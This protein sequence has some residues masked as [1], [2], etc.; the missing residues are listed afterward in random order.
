M[1]FLL[2]G[3][4]A[5]GFTIGLKPVGFRREKNLRG[6]ALARAQPK[7]VT[8]RIDQIGAV[9][10]VEVEISDAVVDQ[11]EHLFGGDRGRDQLAG[12]RISSR[13]SKRAASQSGTEAPVRAAK[14]LVCLKFCTGGCRARPGCRC[15][16][17]HALEIAEIHAVFEK[18]LGDCARRAGI[19]FGLEHVDVGGDAG[20]VGVLFS[21]YAETDTSISAMRLIPAT[22]SAALR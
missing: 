13:P 12:C 16:R 17:P 15:R 7:Q 5:D 20:A 11:I 22:R 19:H 10:G 14:L 8:N 4:V 9:H 18:E 1:S 3:S 2:S 21:G 6:L